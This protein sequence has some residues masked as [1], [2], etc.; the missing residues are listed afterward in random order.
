ML[1][2]TP[3]PATTIEYMCQHRLLNYNPGTTYI[4]SNFSYSL[5]GRVIEKVT[6]M[7]Y[8]SYIKALFAPAGV[9]NM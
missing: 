3:S 9:Q 5:L 8:G 2:R 6:G 1:R 4:Y 7:T